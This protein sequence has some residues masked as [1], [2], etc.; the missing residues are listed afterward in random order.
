MAATMLVEVEDRVSARG[1][2]TAGAEVERGWSALRVGERLAVLKRARHGLA[3]AFDELVD[4]LPGLPTRTRA[5]SLASEVLPLLEACRFLEREAESILRTRVLGRRRLPFWLS[6]VDSRVER[7]ALGKILIVGPANYPLML[8]GVQALQALAAGNGVV[9][10]PGRGGEAVA[11]VFARVLVGAGL[12]VGLL[13]VTG[14]AV[15]EVVEALDEAP[16]KVIFTGSARAGRVVCGMAAERGVPVV[17]ELSGC[18][19]VVALPTADVER[20]AAALAFGMRLNGSA[21]CMAPR[22]L[23]VVGEEPA[24]LVER[25]ISRFAEVRAVPLAQA[26][27]AQLAEDLDE[28][29]ALGATIIGLERAGGPVLVLDARPEMKIARADVFA[30]VLSVVRVRDKAGL[31]A[32][33]RECPWCLT[34]A[35]FGNEAEARRVGAELCA[36]TVLINDLI[37]PTAD[38][39]VP[40]GGRKASGWGVTRGAEGLL[41]MTAVKTVLARRGKSQRHYEPTRDAHEQLFKG[42]AGWQHGGGWRARVAGLKTMMKAVKEMR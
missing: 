39:R 19:A 4:A 28:A 29:G 20:L 1:V 42:L 5:D 27:E 16:D 35:V 13:R 40:F 32:A 23:F 34:V 38:P 30:P 14:E 7:V 26:T 21:T 11:R 18:D 8:P 31:L 22:R 41:E 10:K 25:L 17:A 12:P 24:G 36:G 37:V 6:G 2:L 3:A 15:D 33:Y 9:W